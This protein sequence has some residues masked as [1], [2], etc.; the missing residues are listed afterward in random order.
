MAISS[1]LSTALS[2]LN[3]HQTAIQTT[4]NN[5]SN[6]SN[7]D[8]VRERAVFSTLPPINSIPGDIGTGVNISKIYRITDTFVFNQM[9][10]TS[11][12]LSKY[13]TME[14]YLQQIS[15]YFPDVEDKGLFQDIKDFFNAWQ[16]LASNPNDG[17]AK[18][19]L[20]SKTQK[21]SDTIHLL[22]NKI[23]D[24]QKQANEQIK[25]NIDEANNIIKQIANLNKQINSHEA[26]NISNANELRDKRDALEK[27]LKELL[28]VKVFKND[29]QSI[30][31]QGEETIDYSKDYQITLGGYNLLNN[32]TY[33]ELKLIDFNGNNNI[34]IQTEDFKLKDITKSI[35]GEVGGLL[36]IRGYEFNEDT[37]PKDGYLGDLLS[38]LN[39]LAQ[40]LIRSTNSIYSYS[41][42][43]SVQ[44][45]SN[46]D[47]VSISPDLAN[48]P[49]PTIE[50]ILKHPVRDGNMILNI[51]DDNG[52]FQEDITIPIDKNKSINQIID[53]INSAL[54][55]KTTTT[56][57]LVNGQIKF[58]TPD[59]K[60]SP[61]VLVKDDG[62]LLFS[63]LGDI[64]YMP[65]NK[66]NTTNLPIP[67]ENGNF[68]VVVYSS[69]GNELARRTITVNMDSKDPKY[70]T[71]EGIIAQINTPNI[72]DNKDNNSNNDVDDYYTAKLLNG[73]FILSPSQT[74]TYIGLDNDSVNFGGAFGVN[75]FFD[76]DNAFNINL[77]QEL[78]NDPS[79][80]HAY[81]APNEGNN[82]V[83]NEM[84]QMQFQTISFYKNGTKIEN[85]ISGFYRQT[86]SNLANQTQNITSKKET[87]QTLFTSIQNQY[88]SISGVN[89][90]E[91]LINLE[92]FQRGY[93]ANAKV[94][95][96]IN[97]M[98]DALFG[99]KQ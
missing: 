39:A 1:S 81:K 22:A 93:Q 85:T 91:E 33:H 82:E 24:I 78:A 86:T 99:I 69:D 13:S 7:P 51:Y 47:V 94:I 42:Q 68:D 40:G 70:S 54:N 21:L 89:I 90:D 59:G 75:K 64:E 9:V 3:A 97:Q 58:V 35:D 60:E 96:T 27:R 76:G 73:Q 17:S 14:K 15:T 26:N 32:E 23:K 38:S 29:T 66:I 46:Y 5:I 55:G 18:I 95:T 25:T 80:I 74:N 84:L 92:K 88:Y 2:G 44:T 50:K 63:A 65:L 48:K 53:D 6:A 20:A 28:G 8:Y 83:A 36:Q 41:A 98:L 43:Q 45:D 57:K 72:D 67:L 62:S 79:K 77:N 87:T 16:T 49:L 34:A 4:S 61:N 37:T 11:Q 31:A 52:N 10:K 71:L 12:D 30:Y 56:A 19:D